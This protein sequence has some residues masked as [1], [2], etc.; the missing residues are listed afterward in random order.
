MSGVT[1]EQVLAALSKVQD[2]EL[3]RDLVSLNMIQDVS[4]TGDQVAFTVMLT[5]PACPLKNRI[6]Q[7]ARA[8][9][10]AIPGVSKAEIKMSANVPADGR[11]RGLQGRG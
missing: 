10:M 8:A 9:V 3:H 11:A 6:E 4:V 7:D 1:K 2:P 5:T